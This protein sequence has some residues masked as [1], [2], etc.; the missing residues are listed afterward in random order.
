MARGRSAIGSSPWRD[1]YERL[2]KAGWS[3]TSLERYAAYRFGEQISA[4][5][6]RQY[7]HRKGI[8]SDAQPVLRPKARSTEP[9]AIDVAALRQEMV[10][11][12]AERIAIDVKHETDMT[13]LFNTTGREIDLLGRLLDQ[14]KQD[15]RDFGMLPVTP[16]KI[17][18]DAPD[19]PKETPKAAKSLGDLLGLAS[20]ESAMAAAEALARVI[21]FPEAKQA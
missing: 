20:P 18:V 19:L 16:T 2:L 3:S 9:D 6:F 8:V 4:E 14:V 11:L 21:P 12:Q 10:R 15:Q 5:V 17:E 1:E 13:K 7:K